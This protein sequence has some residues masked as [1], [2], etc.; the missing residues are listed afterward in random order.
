MTEEV[1]IPEEYSDLFESRS[2]AF[3]STLLPDGAPHVTPTWVD[4][5]NDHVLVNTVLDNRKDRNVQHDPRVALAVVDPENPYRYLSVR[6][7]VIERRT[8]GAREH[9]DRLA[10]R[11]T[12]EPRYPG[13]SGQQ[14]VVHVVRP[15]HVTGQAPPRRSE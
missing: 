7:E 1:S 9:L 5:E 12:G 15:D 8:D 2:F 10:E 3:V 11:Y 6:G 4:R 14:R 13:P